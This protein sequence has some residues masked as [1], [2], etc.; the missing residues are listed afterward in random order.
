MNLTDRIVV[1]TGAGGGISVHPLPDSGPPN[2]AGRV[3][4]A[5]PRLGHLLVH[6]SGGQG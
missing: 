1:I 3:T 6:G 5:R 2:H 4:K